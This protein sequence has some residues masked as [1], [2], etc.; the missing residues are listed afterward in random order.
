MASQTRAGPYIIVSQIVEKIRPLEQKFSYQLD[1]L[2]R[3]ASSKSLI[4][5]SVTV[6]FC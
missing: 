3:T 4:G 6:Y 5:Q 2:L 1:K